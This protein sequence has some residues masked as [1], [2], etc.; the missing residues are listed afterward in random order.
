M[1]ENIVLDIRKT[2]ENNKL[3]QKMLMLFVYKFFYRSNVKNYEQNII[4]IIH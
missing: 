3:W 4:I 1:L 2:K